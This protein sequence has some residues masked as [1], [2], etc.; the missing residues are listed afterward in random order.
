MSNRER[1]LARAGLRAVTRRH[2]FRQ[3]GFGLGSLALLDLLD[4]RAFATAGDG[5]RDP[6]AVRP[7]HFAPKAK[8]VIYLFMA[9]APSQVDLLDPKPTLQKHDGQPIPEELVKGERFA[10]IK[11]TPRLL[12]SPYSFEKVGPAGVEVSELLP[13][14]KTIADKAAVV[15]TVHT[16]QFNHAPAQIFMNTGHQ[17]VGRPSMGA[18]LTYGLGSENRDLPGFVVLVSGENNPDGGKSCWGSGFLP[19][20]YQ[21]VELRSSGDPVLFL[22]DPPGVSKEARRDSLDVLRAL[23]ERHLEETGDPEIQT[24][25]GAYELAYRM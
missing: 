12:G 23:N 4:S 2:F 14:F 1:E 16:T 19:T 21:G 24:R 7:P 8:S 10:F 6:L 20:A 17:I 5:V 13:H 3:S 22:T 25:I 15:R 18:W 9:G 11:G